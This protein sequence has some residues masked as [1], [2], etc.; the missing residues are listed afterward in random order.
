MTIQQDQNTSPTTI[1]EFARLQL[2]AEAL[3]DF[4]EAVPKW[5][6]SEGNPQ[7]GIMLFNKNYR[8]EEIY[9]KHLISGNDHNSKFTPTDAAEFAENWEMVAHIAN[10]T[11]GF[12]GSL[13]RA[14]K[15]IPGTDIK[16]GDLT[17]SFRS[18]EFVD[19]ATR[20]SQA[21]NTFEIADRGW[22][23]GQISDMVHWVKI[24]QERGLIDKPLN[25]TGYSLG[26]HL[27]TAF[28]ILQRGKAFNW[29][30]KKRGNQY[31]LGIKS[32]YTFNGAGVGRKANKEEMDPELLVD[33]I[34]QFSDDRQPGKMSG[35]FKTAD[36]K[37]YYEMLQNALKERDRGA[38]NRITNEIE[39]SITPQDVYLANSAE[40]KTRVEELDSLKEAVSKAKDIWDEAIRVSKLRTSNWV[41]GD[42]NKHIDL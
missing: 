15:D 11:T 35:L 16:K 2:A 21:T 19:D 14:K 28:N 36:G 39:K 40:E 34:N 18:T 41:E 5:E 30:D 27:A 9:K 13:F 12:S 10:T 38:V 23:F 3:Y 33:I 20:D 17:I 42:E 37:R 32:T 4:K 26:G 1:L 7:S 6:D 8:N 31:S 24:L 25:V 22:A 29:E